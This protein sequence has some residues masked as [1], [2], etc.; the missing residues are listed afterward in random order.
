MKDSHGGGHGSSWG[1]RESLT[2]PL[3]YGQPWDDLKVAYGLNSR[4]EWRTG[5]NALPLKFSGK[6]IKPPGW[7]I[8]IVEFKK[9]ATALAIQKE[10]IRKLS[11][12]V[13]TEWQKIIL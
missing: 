6:V 4:K 9:L 10:K 13:P 5:S 2:S 11:E 3:T 1:K 7:E 12:A 8:Y